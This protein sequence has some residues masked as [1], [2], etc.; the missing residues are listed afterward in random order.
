MR[1]ML[2]LLGAIAASPS[3]A[4][5]PKSGSALAYDRGSQPVVSIPPAEQGLQTVVAEPWLSISKE[6][7]ALAG[8]DNKLLL[9]GGVF[10]R[11]G[12]LLIVEVIG[13]RVMRIAPDRTLS[14][15]LPKNAS[16]SAGVAI[17]KDGRIFVAAVG[18][19]K[20][21]G[22]V[23][24]IRPDGSGKDVII[25][26]ESGYVPDDLVF[27]DD[28]GFYF[29]D[30][31][32]D[33][34]EPIGQ[35]VYMSPDRKSLTPV[36][37]RLSMPNGIMLSP[38]G[39]TLWVGETGR[40]LLHRI[41]LAAPA[42]IGLF[43]TTIAYHFTGSRADSIRVDKDGNV[44]VA[45]VREGRVLVFDP[46]GVPIAQILIPGREKGDMLVTTSMAI[47]PGTKD[48][49]ILTSDSEGR[50]AGIFRTQAFAEAPTLFSHR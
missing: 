7:P 15:L 41:E 16:G 20:R 46:R 28:G 19:M 34:A 38:D 17:H 39:K 31:R 33:N 14:V 13:G 45:L 24:A 21:G 32:G 10:D 6:T 22:S 30:F 12:N 35:V 4:Q 44:Y 1:G 2:M 3:Y 11:G 36:M 18:D 26:P 8:M 5:T 49:Y 9:E 43:G 50:S 29:T 47:K 37:S 27:D 48:L 42:K 40:G 25:P 23:Y